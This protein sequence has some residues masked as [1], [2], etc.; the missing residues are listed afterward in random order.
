MRVG[1]LPV[2]PQPIT[3]PS[4]NC[5][6]LENFDNVREQMK[7]D[8]LP[9]WCDDGLFAPAMDIILSEPTTFKNIFLMLGPF[10]WTKILL[11]CEGRLFAGSGIDDALK[12]CEV[13]GPN[14]LDPVIN[15]GHYVRSMTAVLLIQDV[16]Y[17]LIW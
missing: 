8:V 12:E 15:G 13:F 16:I 11:R 7:Q 9:V 3:N 17:K 2:I 5:K 14:V 10:H 6:A 1:F 4:T